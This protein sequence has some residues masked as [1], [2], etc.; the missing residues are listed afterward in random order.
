[1]L[2]NINALM[3]KHEAETNATLPKGKTRSGLNYCINQEK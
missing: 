2:M 1:M 3:S